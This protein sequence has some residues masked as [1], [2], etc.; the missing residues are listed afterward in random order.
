MCW[1]Q[2]GGGGMAALR[3][4]SVSATVSYTTN[5]LALVSH[6]ANRAGSIIRHDHDSYHHTFAFAISIKT[7]S[8]P[9]V[10]KYHVFIWICLKHSILTT[11]EDINQLHLVLSQHE[12]L[13]NNSLV[14]ILSL[15]KYLN[16]TALFEHAASRS[17]FKYIWIPLY[18]N[19]GICM[20]Y[21]SYQ[22]GDNCVTPEVTCT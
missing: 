21:S 17:H 1:H 18:M 16:S 13:W 6:A 5:G 9:Y 15:H 4:R 3:N 22:F 7:N 8:R 19:N 12:Y 10:L 20:S 2:R 14:K 11:N